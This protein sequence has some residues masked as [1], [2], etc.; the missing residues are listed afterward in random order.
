MADEEPGMPMRTAEI[1][2][3]ETPPIQMASRRMKEVS[4]ESPK[5]TGSRRAMPSVAERPGMAPKTMPR[6]TMAKINSRLT[7]FKQIRS[8][9]K[10]ASTKSHLPYSNRLPVGR[11]IWKPKTN[12]AYRPNV[13][14]REISAATRGFTVVVPFRS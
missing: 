5:V 14:A 1:K 8:A 7:G 6:L 3:P 12:M 2:A 11:L 13:T 4:E 9:A 10:Y